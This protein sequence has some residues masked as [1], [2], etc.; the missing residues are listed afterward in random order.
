MTFAY[1]DSAVWLEELE[2]HPA[3]LGAN[4]FDSRRRQRGS[5]AHNRQF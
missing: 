3:D 4:L 1:A 2:S 5:V